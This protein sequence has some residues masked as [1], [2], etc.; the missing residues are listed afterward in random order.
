[1]SNFIHSSLMPFLFPLLIALALALAAP[2]VREGYRILRATRVRLRSRAAK[3]A[4][5]ALTV[6]AGT[7]VAAAADEVRN[8]KDPTKPGEWNGVVARRIADRVISEVRSLGADL[9]T[10]LRHLGFIDAAGLSA[11]LES[12]VE[13]Q[14]ERLRRLTPAT[15]PLL[16]ADDLGEKPPA[17]PVEGAA[18]PGALRA[19]T[20]T[21][22]VAPPP[23]E[24]SQN[25]RGF[26]RPVLLAMI[27]FL[28]F[29][30]LFLG[31]EH[32][33][34]G[35]MRVADGV[36]QPSEC[37]PDTQRCNGGLPE[38]CSDSNLH[39]TRWWPSLPRRA[40][41]TQRVCSTGCIVTDA[42]V[43][44]CAPVLLPA[45]PFTSDASVSAEGGAL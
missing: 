8:L 20:V 3:A 10:Q 24:P 44:I 17:L 37:V 1:M 23:A 26:V 35:V 21:I 16:T 14:V 9:I 36:P 31:C 19:S 39:F 43:A 33:R 6:I 40:D 15:L 2:V 34:E 42:G 5:D 38:V 45:N 29:L 32:V 25:Q 18:A 41:G 11:L 27:L 22:A 4:L 13:A 7:A 12:M 28:A 30:P